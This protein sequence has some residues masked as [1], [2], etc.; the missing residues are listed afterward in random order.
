M[1][2]SGAGADVPG[3]AREPAVIG[4]G[5][6]PTSYDGGPGPARARSGRAC[7]AVSIVAAGRRQANGLARSIRSSAKSAGHGGQSR[8]DCVHGHARA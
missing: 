8:E 5:F 6:A 7:R 2:F 4:S 3:Q 1:G